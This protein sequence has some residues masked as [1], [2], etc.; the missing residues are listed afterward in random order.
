MSVC[1]H[2]SESG[3][4]LKGAS[5]YGT[6]VTPCCHY[7]NYPYG[8]YRKIKLYYYINGDKVTAKNFGD[9]TNVTEALHQ[10]IDWCKENC[11]E[12]GLFEYYYNGY[13]IHAEQF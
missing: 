3:Q 8:T 12:R 11:E 1:V 5:P 2:E 13:R 9:G 4:C 10:S 6:C 7:I